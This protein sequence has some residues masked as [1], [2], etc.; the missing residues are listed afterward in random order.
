[1]QIQFNWRLQKQTDLDI[2][3]LQ[4]HGI[5]GLSRTRDQNFPWSC[6]H[7]PC[8][9]MMVHIL[10]CKLVLM[11]SFTYC[12]PSLPTLD[13]MTKFVLMI[14]WLARNLTEVLTVNGKSCKNIVFNTS[15]SYDW[16]DF[17]KYLKH[18]F[19]EEI[20]IKQDLY[21]ISLC[22]FRILYYSNFISMTTSFVA[23]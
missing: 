21:N 10:Q 9:I 17:N 2:H 23:S 13:K 4:R 20:R 5:S 8:V 19:Y 18:L 7:S 12:Q 6:F 15:K 11:F 3:C 1:M 14:I 16:G 22:S